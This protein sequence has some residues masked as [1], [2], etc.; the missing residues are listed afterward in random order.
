MY[1]TGYFYGREKKGFLYLRLSQ[2]ILM[3]G[4]SE[5]KSPSVDVHGFSQDGTRHGRALNMPTRPSLSSIKYKRKQLIAYRE[6]Y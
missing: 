5:I 3:M 6:I 2:F 1:H 4:E